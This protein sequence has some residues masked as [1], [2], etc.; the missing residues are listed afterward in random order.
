MNRLVFISL[1]VFFTGFLQAQI[2]IHKTLTVENGLVQSNINAIHE[3]RDGYLWFA[4]MDG[5]SRWDGIN[6]TNF[7]THNGLTASQIY[8]IY[9]DS[10]GSIYFPAYGGGLCRYKNGRME[11]VFPQIAQADSD[12]AAIKKD[13]YGNFYLGGYQGISRIDTTGKAEL[14]DSSHAVWVME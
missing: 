5:V 14:I 1:L 7:Q 2:V 6:F 4:T 3:D 11:Q 9:E 12:L 13:E 10:D 8:D